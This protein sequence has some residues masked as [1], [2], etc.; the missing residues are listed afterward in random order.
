M[1]R[2]GIAT[3]VSEYFGTMSSRT[4]TQRLHNDFRNDFKTSVSLRYVLFFLAY[5]MIM[6]INS[7]PMHI[8][9]VLWLLSYSGSF[10][11][12]GPSGIWPAFCSGHVIGY[13]HFTIP[14]YP[15]ILTR[16]IGT[17]C[18][19]CGSDLSFGLVEFL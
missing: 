16:V 3:K 9:S 18:D 7:D 8:L 4:H 10:E 15:L 12:S 2:L 13:V 19:L 11:Y 14:R 6:W 5:Y 1:I 17:T